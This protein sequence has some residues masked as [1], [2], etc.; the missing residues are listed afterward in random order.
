MTDKI[1]E[2]EKEVRTCYF[3]ETTTELMEVT[4]DGKRYDACE[5]CI[6]NVFRI[7]DLLKVKY[8]AEIQNQILISQEKF[9]NE[10][11][12]KQISERYRGENVRA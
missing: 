9:V 11:I 10:M 12:H 4:V 3:C 7:L 2:E 6:P 1:K 8:Q 5:E